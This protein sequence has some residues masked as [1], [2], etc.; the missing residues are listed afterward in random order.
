MCKPEGKGGL[1]REIWVKNNVI[2]NFMELDFLGGGGEL[3]E[4]QNVDS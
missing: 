1:S 4:P 3:L 2:H